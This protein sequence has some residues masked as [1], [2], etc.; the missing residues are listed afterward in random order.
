MLA[1]ELLSIAPEVASSTDLLNPRRVIRA[2]ERVRSNSAYSPGSGRKKSEEPP[3]NAMIIGL[4]I[5]RSIL[6]QRVLD[7]LGTMLENGWQAEVESLISNGYSAEDRA[8]SGIGYRQMISH[9]AGE[10]DLDAAVRLTAVATNRL[11]RHQH[12]WFKQDHPGIHWF[13]MTGNADAQRKTIIKTAKAWS[14]GN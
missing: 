4:S 10:I 3:F 9:L 2:I 6:H 5:E 13:D 8:M 12:N 7:R 1:Q 14:S 11:I